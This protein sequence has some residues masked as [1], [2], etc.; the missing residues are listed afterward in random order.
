MTISATDH[1]L[2]DD[3]PPINS[4]AKER[5]GFPTQK[6]VALLQRI[7]TAT[8]G[9][10]GSVLDPF[11]GCGTTVAAAEAL[12]RSWTGIDITYLAVALIQQR[13]NDSY[14]GIEYEVHGVPKD[15]D[16]ARA[17]FAKSTKN[18]EMWAVRQIGGRPQPKMG[19]DEGIDGVIRFYIDGKDW[20]T[21]LVSVKG[22]DSLNPAMVRD[23]VGTVKKD[24]ADMGILITRA[25]P[26]KG[27]YETATKDGHY[28]WPG[29]G[30]QFPRTQI[31]TV[32]DILRGV[33]AD[34][35]PIHGTYAEAPR[36][37]K[38]QGEQ[39]ELGG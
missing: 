29:T 37:I 27:M 17:L 3:I 12:G 16:G 5:L 31:L 24:H 21:V 11:C 36:A 2:W 26:T 18:F 10:A 35:P 22:G 4:Q 1:T 6:P 39:L 23:L 20:G 13:L 25:K 28:T 33:I 14:P 9:D 30:Q 34:L 15:A 38:G 8:T 32:E 7:I 19:G